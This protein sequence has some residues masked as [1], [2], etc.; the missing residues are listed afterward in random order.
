MTH[1]RPRDRR[2]PR[3]TTCAG[4]CWR[5]R[6]T[7]GPGLCPGPGSSD[8]ARAQRVQT[9]PADPEAQGTG[10]RQKALKDPAD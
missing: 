8:G 10:L 5:Q 3:R 7:A 2:R 4:G 1:P 9:A 6:A